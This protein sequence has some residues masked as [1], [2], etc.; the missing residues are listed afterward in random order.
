MVLWSAA[1]LGVL[2]LAAVGLSRLRSSQ[3]R[4]VFDYGA[5]LSFGVY[6]AHPL[7]LD[8]VQSVARRLGLF[9]ASPWFVL[10]SFVLAAAGSVTL[11]ALVHRTRFSLAVMGRARRDCRVALAESS[12]EPGP[13]RRPRLASTSALILIASIG[14]VL[15]ISGS[16]SAPEVGASWANAAQADGTGGAGPAGR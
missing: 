3:V 14:V 7:V 15:G 10:V 4:V 5:Q 6:L 1:A 13:D 16:Q 12:R 9:A 11:C 2:Y 8:V